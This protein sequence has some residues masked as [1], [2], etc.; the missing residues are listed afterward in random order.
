M[1]KRKR[2]FTAKT[3]N[4]WLKQ[5]R[6]QG[7]GPDYK[8]WYTIHDIA[9][10]GL[11]HRIKS[12]WTTGRE[13]HLLS[14]LERDWF[15][16]FDWSPVVLDIR[17]QFPLLP[18]QETQAIAAECGIKYPYDRRSREKQPLVLT[19]D[20]RLTISTPG[21]T[22]DQ[23]RT[24]KYAEKLAHPRVLEKFEIERRYWERRGV[25]WGILTEQNLPRN[26]V[27]N[28]ELLHG[29]RQ[30]SERLSLSAGQLY[31]LAQTLTDTV[32]REDRP[33]RQVTAAFDAQWGLVEGTALTLVYYLL[34]NRY[35]AVDMFSPINPGRRLTLIRHSLEALAP[36]EGR[37]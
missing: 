22:F 18:L 19:S 6:G 10:H 25:A 11:C 31:R 9:S 13:T 21:C 27:R 37:N 29:K 7:I 34:A 35:W 8:P 32:S 30:L 17:E 16:V 14:N 24:V 36:A 4:E 2:I 12:A 5:G 15:F 20:F 23:V 1:S 28:I 3:F 33:L 26:L